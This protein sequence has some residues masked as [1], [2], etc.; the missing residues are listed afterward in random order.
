MKGIRPGSAVRWL[1]PIFICVSRLQ[2]AAQPL[3][4]TEKKRLSVISDYPVFGHHDATVI[5]ETVLLGGSDDVASIVRLLMQSFKYQVFRSLLQAAQYYVAQSTQ[6]F[7]E[8]V[9]LSVRWT[10]GRRIG[11]GVRPQQQSLSW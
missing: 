10:W 3:G 8:T 1:M 4:I 9:L 2:V 5:P 11:S 6:L 7:S